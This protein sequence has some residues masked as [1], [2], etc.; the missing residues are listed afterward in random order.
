[1]AEDA[2]DG[3]RPEEK[4][5]GEQSEAPQK[6]G[7]PVARW[8]M[9]LGASLAGALLG[10]LVA[11]LMFS[12]RDGGAFPHLNV[13]QED[14][15]LG[16]TLVPGRRQKISFSGNPIS[17]IE[18]GNDGF[19]QDPSPAPDT[20][21]DQAVLVVGDS[22]V[23]GLGVNADETFSARLAATTGTPVK[24]AGVPTY[25][26]P[27]YLR[28]IEAQLAKTAFGTVVYAVNFANDPFEANRPNPER[29]RVW[30][31][32]AVRQETAPA[33]TTQFPG[34]TWLYRDSHAFFAL[35]KW[36]YSF[37]SDSAVR[38]LPSD[39]TWK[40]LVDL[41]GYFQ[42]QEEAA[43]AESELA[44][45]LYRSHVRHASL[46]ELTSD[47]HV[48]KLAY[49][50]TKFGWHDHQL[51][52]ASRANPGD[53]VIPTRGEEGPPLAASMKFVLLA[54]DM[55][56]KIE[57]TL[58][59][60]AR[61]L[62]DAKLRQKIEA[63]FEDRARWETHLA[64]VL[65]EPLRFLRASYPLLARAEEARQL[66][67]SK[68][69]RFVLLVLPVDVMVDP[70]EWD[71][72]GHD[73]LDLAPAQALVDELTNQMRRQ[74]VTAVDATE[75]LRAA[76]PG[77]FLKG[78]IHMTPK[79]HE[80]VARA[81]AQ[82]LAEKPPAPQPDP[83]VSLPP[84]R[85][86]LPPPQDWDH[87]GEILVR[88]SSAAGC[89]TKRLREWFYIQCP[90]KERGTAGFYYYYNEQ[91]IE[92]IA[93][94]VAVHVERGGHGETLYWNDGKVMTFITPVL[95][96]E[97]FQ[98]VFQW[99]D[100]TR[101][102]FIDWSAHPKHPAPD[103]YFNKL[104][105]EEAAEIATRHPVPNEARVDP[106]QRKVCECL[107]KRQ[108]AP[109]C[110]ALP[111]RPHEACLA[112]FAND[113][114]ALVECVTGNPAM[115]PRCAPGHVNA[116]A[117]LHCLPLKGTAKSCASEV[118][119]PDSKQSLCLD[120]PNPLA[121]V[122]GKKR[123]APEPLR[124]EE[125]PPEEL[126]AFLDAS[127]ALVGTFE[128]SLLVCEWERAYSQDWDFAYQMYDVCTF[129]PADVKSAKATLS[130]IEAAVKKTPILS[131]GERLL[132]LE[133]ARQFSDWMELASHAEDSRGT[134][135]LYGD[136]A[137]A[138]NELAK[139]HD[140][141]VTPPAPPHMRNYDWDGKSP[142]EWCQGFHG[143]ATCEFF[144]VFKGVV[145]RKWASQ[146]SKMKND[147]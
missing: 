21:P 23:F 28:V 77:S 17:R 33:S 50:N 121:A 68:G 146:A 90:L 29:H 136:L 107:A 37:E 27:E 35:R 81:L 65:N 117:L 95:P 112:T 32:W 120:V 6:P 67:E 138:W 114:D 1:M 46:A 69:A 110:G 72:Y 135:L 61:S 34:R 76:Q 145:P 144:P 89:A 142:I 73:P 93:I 134:L 11:E 143:P 88:G 83:L 36:L 96:G 42:K 85:S 102:L 113:C 54:A 133:E 132:W 41:G 49:D 131:K 100:A 19:R 141:R 94:P 123:V 127:E 130:Q 20:A 3:T 118:P 126:K 31:G 53:I 40:D 78:D 97:T 47:K 58:R 79:G 22:Q 45:R 140:R 48:K 91:K 55:K 15:A 101:R 10:L 105:D 106:I 128:K 71:K 18:I 51:Y 70:A 116:G 57:T 111:A 39:G 139:Q 24:N 16:V 30:D 12:L 5:E 59:D 86:R 82:A 43:E 63:G 60:E 119:I 80:A 103:A 92:D 8:A 147:D 9:R 25:G 74:G 84:G 115:H 98:A 62:G 44:T 124:S 7:G 13:Y 14:A 2:P 56:Q 38:V 75:A 129:A 87:R 122:V 66:V 99:K 52:L 26:P 108:P 104:D 109:R 64:A 137:R 4:R 125:P